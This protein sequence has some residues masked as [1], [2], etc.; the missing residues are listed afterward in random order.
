MTCSRWQVVVHLMILL[1]LSWHSPTCLAVRRHDVHGARR[2][3]LA[4]RWSQYLP[5]FHHSDG[6]SRRGARHVSSPQLGRHCEDS[7]TMEPT[8]PRRIFPE[9]KEVT[10]E[11]YLSGALSGEMLVARLNHDLD[12]KINPKIKQ[13]IKSVIDLREDQGV[14][15][16]H[17]RRVKLECQ[18]VTYIHCP[19]GLNI[20]D[21]CE[22]GGEYFLRRIADVFPEGE[23]PLTPVL[24]YGHA[25]ERI[26]GLAAVL[27]LLTRTPAPPQLHE[28]LETV[29]E[30]NYEILKQVD[31]VFFYTFIQYYPL[32]VSSQSGI[33]EAPLPESDQESTEDPHSETT[34]L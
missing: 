10:L 25:D 34:D 13:K 29:F 19:I 32:F 18:D 30:E 22:K 4:R 2:P 17:A 12:S 27:L 20:Q 24:I 3:P 28:T 16:L 8:D 7:Q 26:V 9:F 11:V 1:C 23:T 33:Y 5:T 31:P 6:R 15:G 21:F 14:R